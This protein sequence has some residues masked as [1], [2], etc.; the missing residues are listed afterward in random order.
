MKREKLFAQL[1]ADDA[2]LRRD[3]IAHLEVVAGG[4]NT[5]FFVVEPVSGTG[6]PPSPDGTAILG[7]ARD[8]V[9]RAEHLQIDP[10]GL[11]APFVE[12]AFASANDRSNEHRLGPIRHA[13]RLLE[14]LR[15][16]SRL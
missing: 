13:Q 11:V 8:I 7:R 3:F 14:E 15:A 4:R 10:A 2:E 16:S 5:W 12:A 6:L 9:A 1:E